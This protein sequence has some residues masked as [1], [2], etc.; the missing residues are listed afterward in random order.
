MRILLVEDD[1]MIG[2]AIEAALKEASYA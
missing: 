1:L 2:E